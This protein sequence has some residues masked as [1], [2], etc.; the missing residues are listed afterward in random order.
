VNTSAEPHHTGAVEP[1]ASSPASQAEDT[2]KH[3][4]QHTV[5]SRN[6]RTLTMPDG[7]GPADVELDGI[8]VGTG[9]PEGFADPVT[10]GFADFDAG[11]WDGFGLADFVGRAFTDL[12]GIGLRDFAVADLTGFVGFALA[13]FAVVIL[14]GFVDLAAL[15]LRDFVAGAL[16]G[17]VGRCLGIVVC[18]CVGLLVGAFAGLVLGAFTGLVVGGFAGLVV[19]SFAGLVVCGLDD[20]VVCG[21]AALVVCLAGDLTMACRVSRAAGMAT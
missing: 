17:V 16:A 19:C 21:V 3:G 11:R 18:G 6:V 12:V 20:F 9:F 8:F 10:C 13:D 4:Q 2:E 7:V 1:T 5:H 14:A 15:L